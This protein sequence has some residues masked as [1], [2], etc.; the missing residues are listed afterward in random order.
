MIISIANQKG[1]VGK[2]TTAFNI[3]SLLSKTG[4]TLLIDMDSQFSL[5]IYTGY[6]PEDFSKNLCNLLESDCDVKEC[7]YPLEHIENLYIIPSSIDLALLEVE[8]VKNNSKCLSIL[9]NRL[10]EAKKEF[11]YIVIDCPP[12]LS[13]LTTNALVSSDSVI[14]PVRTDYLSYRGLK[15][16]ENTIQDVKE[17]LNKKLYFAGVIAT[18][19]E[20]SVNE[21]NEILDMLNK[22]YNVVAVIKK[23]AAVRKGMAAGIPVVLQFPKSKITEEYT[24]VAD[25]LKRKDN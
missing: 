21:D 13:I 14:V 23:A 5:T 7:I 1:G 24:K 19:Y 18:M 11:E 2:S 20:K 4:K 6:E 12:Q 3:A 8:L 25:F 9:S 17:N 16:I 22:E 15:L 10:E